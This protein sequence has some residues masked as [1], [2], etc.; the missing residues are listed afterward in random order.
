[1]ERQGEE[2]SLYIFSARQGLTWMTRRTKQRKKSKIHHVLRTDLESFA[3]PVSSAASGWHAAFDHWSPRNP[4]SA[5][6]AIGT[7]FH[8]QPLEPTE[9]DQHVPGSQLPA[10]GRGG[11]VEGSGEEPR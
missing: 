1:L 2:N 6:G 5:I 4:L 7:H 10:A 8:F 11:A 3:R 9:K